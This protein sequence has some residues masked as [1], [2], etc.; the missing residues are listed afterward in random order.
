MTAASANRPIGSISVIVPMFNEANHV[1][2]LVSDLARQDFTGGLHLLV[3]DGRSNGRL[4]RE[5]QRS[6]GQGRTGRYGH[7]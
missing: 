5:A 6:R 2:N 7:R 4:G 3:A 1:E